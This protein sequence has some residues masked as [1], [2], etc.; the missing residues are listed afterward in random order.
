MCNALEP[1][2]A[3][4]LSSTSRELRRGATQALLQQLR[5]DHKAAAVLCL[6]VGMRGCKELPAWQLNC[7]NKGLSVADLSLLG[8]LGSVLPALV[9]LDLIDSSGAAGPGG[10]QRLAEGLGAGALP[11]VTY[12]HINGMRTGDAGAS[13]L[14]AAL[15]RGFLPRLEH[16]TSDQRRHRRRGAGSPRRPCGGARAGGGLS[17]GQPSR[18]RGPRCPRGAA[19]AAAGRWP[20]APP[21]TTGV[22]TIAGLVVKPYTRFC[23]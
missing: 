10:L 21:T 12:L 3:V 6:K 23:A 20:G 2:V 22:L 8:T 11:A 1:R 19:A 15:G 4:D 18:R 16:L 9:T 14:A 17:R 5:S 7:Q 13:A